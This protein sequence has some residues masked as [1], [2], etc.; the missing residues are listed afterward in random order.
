MNPEKLSSKNY[1]NQLNAA[2]PATEFAIRDKQALL[3]GIELIELSASE[4]YYSFFEQF[5]YIIQFSHLNTE[6]VYKFIITEYKDEIRFFRFYSAKWKSKNITPDYQ[7]LIIEPDILMIISYSNQKVKI[8][9][10]EADKKKIECLSKNI[11]KFDRSEEKGIPEV[12]ILSECRDG[13]EVTYHSISTESVSLEDNYNDDFQE[14]HTVIYNRLKSKNSKGIVLLYGNPGTGKTYYIR[15]LIDNIDKDFIIIPPNMADS[16][17]NPAL[18]RTLLENQKSVLI[19]EDAEKLVMD[20]SRKDSPVSSI[21][22]ISDGLLSDCLQIQI[23]CSFNTSLSKVDSALLRKGR[24]IAK[25]E[26]KDLEVKKAQS[27]S[28]KLG[29]ENTITEP[30]SLS[31]IFNQS[32]G[33]FSSNIDENKNKIGF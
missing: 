11:Q 5:P 18:T 27:L 22:N 2:F 26:F 14:A 3:K 12:G 23:I 30:M 1:G 33:D 29:F 4:I 16:L 31:A 8:L 25:Y 17:T 32:E 28:K 20:R 6:K 15:H 10:K 9:W 13:F 21:L 19:I 24:L 7:L